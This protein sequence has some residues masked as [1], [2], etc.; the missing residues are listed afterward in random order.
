MPGPDPSLPP[1]T[2]GPIRRRKACLRSSPVLS[3][4][5]DVDHLPRCNLFPRDSSPSPTRPS[6]P[7]P[8]SRRRRFDPSRVTF[9]DLM[10]VMDDDDDD[11]DL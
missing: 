6:T 4:V 3:P 7:T 5:D 1:S 2:P 8:P 9:R 11:E 10:P